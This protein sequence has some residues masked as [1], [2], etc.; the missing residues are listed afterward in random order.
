MAAIRSI[1]IPL[2]MNILLLQM[3]LMKDFQGFRLETQNQ[4]GEADDWSLKETIV[5]G[6]FLWL[7]GI[8]GYIVCMPIIALLLSRGQPAPIAWSPVI[9]VSALAAY[10]AAAFTLTIMRFHGR[11]LAVIREQPLAADPV[12][13]P[14]SGD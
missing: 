8:L 12:M 3:A 13:L 5:P 11:K 10:P 2:A 14:G 9:V 6:L 1:L 7:F 4:A